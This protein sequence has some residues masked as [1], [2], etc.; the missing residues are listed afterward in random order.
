MIISINFNLP[1]FNIFQFNIQY[2]LILKLLLRVEYE[3]I[4]LTS[5]KLTTKTK[6][7]PTLL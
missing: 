7:L 2:L 4:S 5:W 6:L 1:K 3:R